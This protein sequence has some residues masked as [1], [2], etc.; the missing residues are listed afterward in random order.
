MV[1]YKEVQG[2]FTNDGTVLY[3]DCGGS[4]MEHCMHF[5]KLTALILQWV[6]LLHIK[7]LK[8]QK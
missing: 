6:S 2:T 7:Y 3:L 5:S 8:N 1:D 4:F